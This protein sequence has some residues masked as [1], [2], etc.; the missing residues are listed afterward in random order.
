MFVFEKAFS[1]LYLKNKRLLKPL[2]YARTGLSTANNIQNE[3]CTAIWREQSRSDTLS[4]ASLATASF[5]AAD[6][7]TAI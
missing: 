5:S 4:R 7:Q 6:V 1:N 2:L 3:G